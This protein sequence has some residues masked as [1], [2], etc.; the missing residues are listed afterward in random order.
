VTSIAAAAVLGADS[1]RS[2]HRRSPRRCFLSAERTTDDL[3]AGSEPLDALN[4]D[5]HLA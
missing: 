5:L 2:P 4:A 1:D 3:A